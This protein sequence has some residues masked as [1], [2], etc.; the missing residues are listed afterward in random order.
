MTAEQFP[1]NPERPLGHVI[2]ERIAFW[3]ERLEECS[4]DD[5]EATSIVAVNELDNLWSADGM[6]NEDC[7]I[8]G[9]GVWV[10]RQE[11]DDFSFNVDCSDGTEIEPAFRN[12]IK[13]GDLV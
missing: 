10:E 4:M 13:R 6:Y 12:V 7:I 1:P 3:K 11:I 9:T 8:S 2:T 5:I